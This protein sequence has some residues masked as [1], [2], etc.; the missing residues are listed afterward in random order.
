MKRDW[1]DARAKCDG[2]AGCRVC[3]WPFI[4][5]AHVSGR[6]YDTEREDGVVY[7]HPDSVIPL[8]AEH[9]HSYDEHT[10]DLLP[11]LSLEEQA[12]AAL[13]LGL[14][15]A[16]RRLTPSIFKHPQAIA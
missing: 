15:R 7:V 2:E 1:V 9:H 12:D 6:R 14:E 4:E 13:R 16:Y 10:L 3:G 5:A 11:Y 8:C